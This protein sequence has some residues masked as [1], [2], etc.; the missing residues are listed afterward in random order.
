VAKSRLQKTAREIISKECEA[1][2]HREFP[3]QLLDKTLDEIMRT[4]KQGD[5]TARKALK[6]LNNRRFK[7]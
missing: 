1:G 4:A 5:R 7:K 6:L 3:T 2:I